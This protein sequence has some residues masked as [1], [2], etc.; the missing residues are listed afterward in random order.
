MEVHKY[1]NTLREGSTRP[2]LLNEDYLSYDVSPTQTQ[3][4]F[5]ETEHRTNKGER[6]ITKE[7]I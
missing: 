5:S 4:F 2:G 6:E 1:R 3:C 7:T